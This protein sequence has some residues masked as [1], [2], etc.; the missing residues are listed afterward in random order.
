MPSGFLIKWG[1]LLALP[2]T[3]TTTINFPVTD[4][5]LIPIPAFA[6]ACVGALITNIS[7]G[8]PD[9]VISVQNVTT[10]TIT[11][12]NSGAIASGFFIAIGY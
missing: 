3:A 7:G 6:T 2:A 10:T 12:Y 5:G 8:V 9:Q 11:V 4:A 1:P